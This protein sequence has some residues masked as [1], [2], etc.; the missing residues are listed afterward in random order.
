MAVNK[1]KEFRDNLSKIFIES[2]KEDDIQWIKNWSYENPYNCFSEKEYTGINNFHLRLIQ[3]HKG[4]SDPRW[5]TYNQLMEMNKKIKDKNL[6]YSIKGERGFKVEFWFAMDKTET[7]K[8]PKFYTFQEVRKILKE[9]PEKRE[10][11]FQLVAKYYTVFNGSQ[12][13]NFPEYQ[14]PKRNIGIE[15]SE[16][17]KKISKNMDVPIL[18]DQVDSSFYVSEFDQIHLP[19][20]EQFSSQQAYNFVC[21]HELA[22]ATGSENRL[23]RDT[24]KNYHKDITIRAEE[25][26][27]AEIA[28]AFMGAYFGEAPQEHLDNQ[29][30]YVQSWASVVEKNPKVLIK[31]ISEAQKSADYLE[32]KAE[33]KVQKTHSVEIDEKTHEFPKENINDKSIKHSTDEYLNE[34]MSVGNVGKKKDISEEITF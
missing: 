26:L 22:H 19:D 8:K 13:K 11:D 1:V 2:L 34:I 31:A 17:V 30:A 24:L 15:Q 33:I 12:I 27:V 25:E 5:I 16:L 28:S 29:K 23:N 20:P 7:S 32:Q 3:A 9:N 18:N 6:K 14:A 10:E 4:F 21:L